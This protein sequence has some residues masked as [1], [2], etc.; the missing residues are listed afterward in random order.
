VSVSSTSNVPA[1]GSFLYIVTP[2]GREPGSHRCRRRCRERACVAHRRDSLEFR[3]PYAEQ[4]SLLA[5]GNR[6]RAEFLERLGTYLSSAEATRFLRQGQVPRRAVDP[7]RRCGGQ[8]GLPEIRGT[9]SAQK[10]VASR[11]KGRWIR[12]GS[13]YYSEPGAAVVY[14][15]VPVTSKSLKAGGSGSSR[16]AKIWRWPGVGS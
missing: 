3:W 5:E 8:T 4:S 13:C 2:P 11:E 7:D 1:M 6:R 15:G 12:E 9:R 16:A 14:A 10:V